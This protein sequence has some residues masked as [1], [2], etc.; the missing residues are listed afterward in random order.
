MKGIYFASDA[1]RYVERVA[2]N[3]SEVRKLQLTGGSTYIVSLP[4]RWVVEHQ[5]SAKDDVRI[6]W[7]PSG[8]LRVSAETTSVRKRRQVEIDLQEISRDFILDHLIGAYLSGAQ[9]IRIISKSG[10]DREHRRELRR[11]IQTTRGVEIAN[12]S[13]Y[14]VEMITLLN[15]AEMPLHSSLNRM[16]LLVSSQIR[17][18]VEVLT[19]GDVTILEDSE[20]REKEVD[21]LRLLLERQVGQILE[22]A[23]IETSFGTT[24][25]EAA[26]LSNIVRTLERIGDHCY[27][28]SRLCVYQEVPNNLSSAELPVSVIPIWQSSIKQLIA[29]LRKRKVKEIHDA[30][31]NLESAI[32]NLREYEDSLW[33]MKLQSTDALFLDKLSESLRRIL[34]YTVDMAEI[35]INIHTH[36]NSTEVTIG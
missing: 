7:R 2:S 21:A 5:L 32:M 15:P 16:Y 29:N 8:S 36:R 9:N 33:D 22:S 28:L 11:F 26:E 13:D 18:V 23:S 1:A 10:I 30:K 17:D 12:E 20:E 19:G 27:I 14:S 35:L 24:R 34:A 6:E 25:W 4:K 3:K 31:S